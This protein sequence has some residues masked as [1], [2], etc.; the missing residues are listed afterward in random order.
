MGKNGKVFWVILSILFAV[1]S[2]V[3]GSLYDTK[4]RNNLS[5]SIQENVSTVSKTADTEK[6]EKKSNQISNSQSEDSTEESSDSSPKNQTGQVETA[7]GLIDIIIADGQVKS[8]FTLDDYYAAKNAVDNLAS[9]SEKTALLDK[10]TQIETALTN[11]GIS[12]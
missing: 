1:G 5:S 10:I 3:A 7:Q 2:I 6:E 11:M 8:D 9:S 4:R 12:Y